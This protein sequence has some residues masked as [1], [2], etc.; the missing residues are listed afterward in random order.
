MDLARGSYLKGL[1]IGVYWRDMTALA[2][3]AVA[4]YTLA[5]WRLKK[6]IG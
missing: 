1:G 4:V 3:F 6:R 5:W 2:L